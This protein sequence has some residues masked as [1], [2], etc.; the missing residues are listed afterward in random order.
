MCTGWMGKIFTVQSK[1][2]ACASAC[3]LDVEKIRNFDENDEEKRHRFR[4]T[5]ET[6]I[7]GAKRKHMYE[8]QTDKE[9]GI[10]K[11]KSSEMR[12]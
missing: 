6:I 12:T 9:L 10:E 3:L 1:K 5:T 11:E 2:T 4:V 8:G 7:Q